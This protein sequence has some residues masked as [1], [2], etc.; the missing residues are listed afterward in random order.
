MQ[1]RCQV[2]QK[3]VPIREAGKFPWSFGS[4]VD[5]MP[6]AH[7]SDKE[8]RRIVERRYNTNNNLIG[9][10]TMATITVT[11]VSGTDNDLAANEQA[12]RDAYL[13]H[14]A[15]KEI[16]DT[17]I[18]DAVHSVFDQYLGASINMPAVVS[19]ALRKL[20]AQPE[21]HSYLEK[22]TLEF[23]RCNSQGKKLDD[24]SFENPNSDFVIGKGSKGGVKRRK[25][26]VVDT[27]DKA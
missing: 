3:L 26:I 7:P 1:L 22:R 24:G 19:F 27:A 4:I 23:I 21:N 14:V 9:D 15:Q 13:L 5:A 12:F 10:I 17:N 6:T 25:D 8:A 16:E 18:S 20:N 11:I 2:S